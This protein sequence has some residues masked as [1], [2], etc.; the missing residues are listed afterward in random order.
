MFKKY[1]YLS[2]V[3]LSFMITSHALARPDDMPTTSKKSSSMFTRSGWQKLN[4][5]KAWFYRG[6]QYEVDNKD[7]SNEVFVWAYWNAEHS[8]NGGTRSIKALVEL[9]C[10]E[11]L[12]GASNVSLYDAPDLM[13][14]SI[15]QA[16][17]EMK[18]IEPET[19]Y[20]ALY[21]RFC[22]NWYEKVIN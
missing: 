10:G 1:L 18:A 3:L 7:G 13:G 2:T 5:F 11:R 14:R 21:R 17:I 8:T 16:D 19:F 15:D 4:H 9:D 22:L 6:S 12:A 20:Y